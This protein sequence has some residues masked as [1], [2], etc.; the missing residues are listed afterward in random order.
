MIALAAC[1]AY[2]G[3]LAFAGWLVYLRASRA[4][5]DATLREE[6]QKLQNRVGA[7][8]VRRNF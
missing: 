6:L 5:G 7:L 1:M 4:R 2:L 3:T 8:E